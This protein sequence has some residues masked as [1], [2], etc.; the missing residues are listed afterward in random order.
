MN[1]IRLAIAR[2][3]RAG[4]VFFAGQSLLE[5]AGHG[6]PGPFRGDAFPGALCAGARP[7]AAQTELVSRGVSISSPRREPWG[8]HEMHVTDPD[9]ITLIFVRDH[10]S[11][12]VQTPG[13]ELAKRLGY[14]IGNI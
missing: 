8:L 7:Q 1:Q 14:V 11:R 5:L 13:R 12:C 3:Y 9:R 6:E 2:E 10:G 4:T